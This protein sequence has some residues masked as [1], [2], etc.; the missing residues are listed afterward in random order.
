MA[1]GVTFDNKEEA[2]EYE[3]AMKARNWETLLQEGA[4]PGTWV[5]MV[6][7]YREGE[8]KALKKIPETTLDAF[9]EEEHEKGVGK[10]ERDRKRMARGAKE[11][12]SDVSRTL[13]EAGMRVVRGGAAKDLLQKTGKR[14][15]VIGGMKRAIPRVG[16]V[17]ET[18]RVGRMGVARIASEPGQRM[19]RGIGEIPIGDS[20]LGVSSGMRFKLNGMRFQIPK[21]GK[22]KVG[23]RA[24]SEEEEL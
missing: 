16:K 13:D 14:M 17:E 19:G 3:R 22:L 2:K 20:G 21:V 15:D 12:K 18:P 24:I 7:E 11:I 23:H 8:K 6:S 9:L 4:H 1:K 10:L 5:V